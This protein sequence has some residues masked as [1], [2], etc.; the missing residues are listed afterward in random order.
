MVMPLAPSLL[1]MLLSGGLAP[2]AAVPAPAAS[3]GAAAAVRGAGCWGGAGAVAPAAAAAGASTRAMGTTPTSTAAASRVPLALAALLALVLWGVGPVLVFAAEMSQSQSPPPAAAAAGRQAL[4]V[5]SWPGLG[6]LFFW[7]L[8][9]LE[10]L[11]THF[12]DTGSSGSHQPQPHQPQPPPLAVVGSSS[13]GFIAAFAA[14]GVRPHAALRAAHRLVLEHRV[15]TRPLGLAG[16]WGGLVRAWLHE[17][18]PEDAAERCNGGCSSNSCRGGGGGGGG[19]AVRVRVR[20]VVTTWP[21][22]HVR[23]LGNF[24]SKHDLIEVLAASAHIPYFMDWRPTAPCRGRRVLDGSTCAGAGGIG[25]QSSATEEGDEEAA[26]APAVAAAP[27]PVPVVRKAHTYHSPATTMIR[28]AAGTHSAAA[29]VAAGRQEAVHDSCAN[30]R[31]CH[32]G[33]S[34]GNAPCGGA[35]SS[36]GRARPHTTST[37]SP[38]PYPCP[39]SSSSSSSSSTHRTAA[40]T[41]SNTTAAPGTGSGC[42]GAGS[43]GGGCSGGGCSSGGCSSGGCS[44]GGGVLVM[45]PRADD[46]LRA[47]WSVA[48]CLRA[49]SL[50]GAEQLMEAGAGWAAQ[51]H[52]AGVLEGLRLPAPA[53][54]VGM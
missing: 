46:A 12:S 31:S 40:S 41:T 36:S 5:L 35:C 51:L 23:A 30:C 15:M 53:R 37:S 39:G 27:A 28:A 48:A 45:D 4:E 52:A 1:R 11:Q 22:L 13:G 33:C 54:G 18:L 32:H 50:A 6:V 19:A 10:Y 8:G 42:G 49:L 20:V 44:G 16:L 14:C 17:L 7:Q 47:G 43:G 21:C 24:R 38:G 3:A 34:S 2:S 25:M 9:V 29:A 26:P